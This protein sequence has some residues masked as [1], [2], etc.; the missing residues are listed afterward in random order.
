MKANVFVCNVSNNHYILNSEKD[1]L[2]SVNACAVPGHAIR[3]VEPYGFVQLGEVMDIRWE[4]R[5]E[6]E[7]EVRA[8]SELSGIKE[9]GTVDWAGH[10][11]VRIV[12]V[13]VPRRLAR[14]EYYHPYNGMISHHVTLREVANG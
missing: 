8:Y 2:M 9:G 3:N 5:M 4:C 14:I 6:D 7:N 10:M 1:G 12:D 13:D 11:N